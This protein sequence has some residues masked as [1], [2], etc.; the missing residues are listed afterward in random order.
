[1]IDFEFSLDRE[2][3]R[4]SERRQPNGEVSY[5]F[6]WL[7]GPAEGTYGFTFSAFGAKSPSEHPP[8]M[9]R[10]RLIEEARGFLQNFYAKNGIGPTDFPDHIRPG[11]GDS[12]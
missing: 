3:F 9:S 6:A 5:D 8:Q 2:L 12:N 1:M 7:N 10:E 4:I 11:D